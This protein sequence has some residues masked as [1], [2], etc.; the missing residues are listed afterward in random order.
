M[1]CCCPTCPAN[2]TSAAVCRCGRCRSGCGAAYQ[3]W[4]SREEWSCPARWRPPG[5]TASV[6]GSKLQCYNHRPVSA[7]PHLEAG[8]AAP[9]VP[10]CVASARIPRA[11]CT[12]AASGAA[13][14]RG[15]SDTTDLQCSGGG[16]W[17]QHWHAS[18]CLPRCATP[19]HLEAHGVVVAIEPGCRP[20]F[21]HQLGKG[22]PAICSKC[23]WRPGAWRCAH[24]LCA[25]VATAVRHCG[26]KLGI[27]N[28]G[29]GAW[30]HSAGKM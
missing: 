19:P 8:W 1:R 11:S 27:P 25:R 23:G 2:A 7:L 14:R 18:W 26:R 9:P 5:R 29:S 15:G 10:L 17:Q 3:C 28:P 4:G 6:A 24:E 13:P 12:A 16:S 20:V 22:S 30:R 21:F